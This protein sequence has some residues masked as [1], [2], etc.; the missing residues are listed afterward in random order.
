VV[1]DLQVWKWVEAVDVCGRMARE[2]V[3]EP[4]HRK[5]RASWMKLRRAAISIIGQKDMDYYP[6]ACN[7]RS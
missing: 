5:D 7:I 4:K 2:L 6:I 3:Y 1:Q